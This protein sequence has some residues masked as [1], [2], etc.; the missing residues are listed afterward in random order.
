MAFNGCSG[1]SVR[2]VVNPSILFLLVMG[3][4]SVQR[5]L[6]AYIV[7]LIRIL[8]RRFDK[9]PSSE[10]APGITWTELQEALV[11]CEQSGS[12]KRI[13]SRIC[14]KLPLSGPALTTDGISNPIHKLLKDSS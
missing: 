13:H 8:R 10:L 2:T 4:P 1:G 7:D 9:T 11:A 6:I 14:S 5:L 12:R 3:R